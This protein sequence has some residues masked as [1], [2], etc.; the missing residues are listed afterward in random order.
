MK[1]QYHQIMDA[2]SYSTL[3]LID[4]KFGYDATPGYPAYANDNTQVSQ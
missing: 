1:S 3:M 2:M 4:Q